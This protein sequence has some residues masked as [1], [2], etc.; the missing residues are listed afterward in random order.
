MLYDG[1]HGEIRRLDARKKSPGSG[2]RQ[3]R[4]GATPVV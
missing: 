2:K 3:Q 1:L 4:L